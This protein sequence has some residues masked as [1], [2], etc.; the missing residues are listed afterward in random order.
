MLLFLENLDG[1]PAWI[2]AKSKRERVQRWLVN[3]RNSKDTL[4]IID[5]RTTNDVLALVAWALVFVSNER[6][7][8]KCSVVHEVA[9]W[10]LMP[11]I[12]LGIQLEAELGGYFEEVYAWYCCPGPLN[13][14]ICFRMLE[15]FDIYLGFEL[16][17]WNEAVT[18]PVS[19]LPKTMKYLEEPFEGDE[20]DFRRKQIMQGLDA[21][22][23]ELILVTT[24]YFSA[25]HSCYF[26]SVTTS[27][28]PR[29]CELCLHFRARARSTMIMSTQ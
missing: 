28:A 19:K 12:I 27:T 13:K 22:R 5:A 15:I 2:K 6:S 16:P 4:V 8:R 26:S 20:L 3:Q 14:R 1:A 9:T 24:K 29:S 21:G 18:G 7:S 23:E 25:H 17:W 11:E 10:A